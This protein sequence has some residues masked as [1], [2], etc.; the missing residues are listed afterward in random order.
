LFEHEDT[1]ATDHTWDNQRLIGIQPTELNHHLIFR[2]NGHGPWQHHGTH[3][4]REQQGFSFEGEL[5]EDKVTKLKTNAV[6]N[7]STSH[8]DLDESESVNT[9]DE[10]S[11]FTY[12]KEE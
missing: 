10:D 4:H 6:I 5:G 9:D 2:N 7:G 12:K 8:K 11:Y 1:E 3:D